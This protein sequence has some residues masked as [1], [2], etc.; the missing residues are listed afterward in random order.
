MGDERR[1]G[2]WELIDPH[3]EAWLTARVSAE[4]CRPGCRCPT[5]VGSD[6]VDQ[7]VLEAEGCNQTR[8]S[9]DWHRAGNRCYH[10]RSGGLPFG[11]SS[12]NEF[13][14]KQQSGGSL[15]ALKDHGRERPTAEANSQITKVGDCVT[16]ASSRTAA[17]RIPLPRGAP[18]SLVLIAGERYIRP[19]GPTTPRRQHL[20]PGTAPDAILGTL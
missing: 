5:E 2:H 12:G 7:S 4:S 13:R 16:L 11:E 19:P 17:P 15:R 10:A 1:R 18:L 9:K 14:V 6:P 20:R 8:P 3:D